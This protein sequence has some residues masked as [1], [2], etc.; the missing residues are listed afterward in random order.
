MGAA[1]LLGWGWG[2]GLLLHLPPRAGRT[3]RVHTCVRVCMCV[4]T[5]VCVCRGV[6]STL[7][8]LHK[9]FAQA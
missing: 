7:A 2:E 1:T 3:E 6:C 5:R 9:L 4:C 8:W